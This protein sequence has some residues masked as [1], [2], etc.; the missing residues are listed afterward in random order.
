MAKVNVPGLK[1]STGMKPFEPLATG[2]YG[3]K[4]MALKIE[5]AKSGAPTNVW[6][7]EAQILDGPDQDDGQAAK[8]RKFYF[9]VNIMDP[10]KHPDFEKNGHWGIDEL[11]SICLAFGVAPKGDTLDPDAFLGTEGTADVIRKLEK[12]QNTGEDIP[13][14]RVNKWIQA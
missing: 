7:F 5:P 9:N 13:R 3:M 14:N 12:D 2:R 10:E 4:I 8:G 6:K 11:K 1:N